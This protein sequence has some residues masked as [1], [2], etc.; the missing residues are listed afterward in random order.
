MKRKG[1]YAMEMYGKLANTMIES[2]RGF[3]CIICSSNGLDGISYR[4]NNFVL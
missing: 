1:I 3:Y 4:N 2:R